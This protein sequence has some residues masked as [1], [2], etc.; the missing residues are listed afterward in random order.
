MVLAV[1]PAVEGMG[2]A[3]QKIDTI[4]QMSS[5]KQSKGAIFAQNIYH[6][7]AFTVF[8]SLCKLSMKEIPSGPSVDQRYIKS[9]FALQVYVCFS[10]ASENQN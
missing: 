2:N 1:L 5:S 8:A 7:G 10:L 3:I 6:E 4:V 9:K